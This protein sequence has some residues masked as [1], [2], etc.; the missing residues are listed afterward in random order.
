MTRKAIVEKLKQSHSLR[1]EYRRRA[2]FLLDECDPDQAVGEFAKMVGELVQAL[3]D[4]VEL[5][6]G[7]AIQQ[8]S[9][10]ALFR[11]K[12]RRALIPV[13]SSNPGVTDEEIIAA[14]ENLAEELRI[15][16]R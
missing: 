16:R 4:Q 2:L 9:W 14:I 6:E 8:V 15:A 11:Q 7:A 1:M 13:W 10:S 5:F 12:V 3:E